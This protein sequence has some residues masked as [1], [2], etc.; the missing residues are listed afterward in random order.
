MNIASIVKDKYYEYQYYHT[1]LDNLDFVKSKY[2]FNSLN[3]YLQ[4]VDKIDKEVLYKS[5]NVNCEVMLS[6][7]D[8][9]PTVGGHQLPSTSNLN[10]LD[11]IL[12]LLWICDGKTSM[13]QIKNKLDIDIDILLS[14]SKELEDK[15]LLIRIA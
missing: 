13:T 11:I 12:W 6:K 7:Y 9:Y 10:K 15:S 5:S 1:S 4:V 2:I 8:L 14:I 3:M